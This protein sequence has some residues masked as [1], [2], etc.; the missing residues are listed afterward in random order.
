MSRLWR[1]DA[2]TVESR[3]V[4]SLSWIRNNGDPN[5]CLRKDVVDFA[6]TWEG[7][8]VLVRPVGLISVLFRIQLMMIRKYWN[9]CLFVRDELGA[10]FTTLKVS[11][12]TTGEVSSWPV[13]YR[14]AC[15][16]ERSSLIVMVS[17]FRHLAILIA[18]THNIEVP[19]EKKQRVWPRFFGYYNDHHDHVTFCWQQLCQR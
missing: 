12:S 13:R 8:A 9:W 15:K 19:S 18:V 17:S 16:M 2:R 11:T 7:G 1:T 5:R 10:I 6:E 4:F 14:I 3:A